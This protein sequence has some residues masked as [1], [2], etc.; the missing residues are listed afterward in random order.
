[1]RLVSDLYLYALNF[2]RWNGCSEGSRRD[3]EIIAI[4][5]MRSVLLVHDLLPC[6]RDD[7]ALTWWWL[8]NPCMMLSPLNKKV[9]MWNCQERQ[10]AVMEQTYWCIGLLI[11]LLRTHLNTVL[12]N[13]GTVCLSQQKQQ[14]PWDSSKDWFSVCVCNILNINILLYS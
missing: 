4:Y 8:S 9:L 13:H 10:F 3:W 11:T 1:M 14:K 5:L 6:K 7:D 2:K 12:T